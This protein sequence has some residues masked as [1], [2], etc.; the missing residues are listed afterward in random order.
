[1]ATKKNKKFKV[2]VG[3]SLTRTTCDNGCGIHADKRLKRQKTRATKNRHEL[4]MNGWE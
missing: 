4:K 1:M 3:Y 2:A